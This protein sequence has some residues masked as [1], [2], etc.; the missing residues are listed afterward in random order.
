[1]RNL[2]SNS[3]KHHPGGEGTVTVAAE[4]NGSGMGLAIV[5]RIVNWQ[6]G[7]IWFEAPTNGAGAVFKFEWKNHPARLADPARGD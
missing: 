3:I 1:M 5:K 7:R 4:R 6:G 2:I